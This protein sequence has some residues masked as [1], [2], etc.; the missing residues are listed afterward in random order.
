VRTSSKLIKLEQNSYRQ[1]FG[2][3]FRQRVSLAISN[4]YH[5]CMDRVAVFANGGLGKEIIKRV[6]AHPN[7]ELRAVVLNS[8]EKKSIEY[9]G[10]VLDLVKD[11]GPDFNIY[12]WAVDLNTDENYLNTLKECEIGISVLFGHVIPKHIIEIFNDKII[13]LHPSL[14]PHGK[15]SDPVPWGI[16]L[17]YNQGASIHTVTEKLDSGMIL[18]Q[19]LIESDIG[20]NAGEVYQKCIDSLLYQFDLII[21]KVISKNFTLKPQDDLHAVPKM[22]FELK[23]LQ[24]IEASEISNLESFIRRIQALTY[25][26]GRRPKFRDK[27]GN[28]WTINLKLMKDE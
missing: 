21:D 8:P 15:G 28:I 4:S 25:S 3:H 22:S 2:Q 14:L 26:D 24:I 7:L 23:K 18:S 11:F 12:E 27:Q 1:Q 17:G 13:N 20:M 19:Q 5:S 9:K 6:I 16:L 10:E